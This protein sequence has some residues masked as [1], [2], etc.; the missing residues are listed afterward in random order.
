MYL[1]AVCMSSLD[2]CDSDLL[3]IFK[4]SIVLFFFSFFFAVDLC[5]F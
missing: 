4:N 1:L 5:G 2:K 3:P